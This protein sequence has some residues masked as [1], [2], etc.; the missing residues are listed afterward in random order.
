[1]SESILRIY[2]TIS[3]K[4]SREDLLNKDFTIGLVKESASYDKGR[5]TRSEYRSQ[6][7]DAMVVE[8]I[9]RDIIV[10][11]HLVGLEMTT[12]WFNEA[13][14]IGLTKTE[15]IKKLNKY[16]A[17]TLLRKRRER[18]IDYL[19][20]GAE[21]TPIEP[22]VNAIF[23]HY[24]GVIDKFEKK[25]TTEFADAINAETDQQILGMLAI[26]LPLS[27]GGSI[28]VKD[29]ILGEIS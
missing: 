13:G 7:D 27:N 3:L 12:N 28:S 29:R 21:D 24:Y 6:I 16:T 8:K 2:R 9:F 5:K 20:A 23:D 26:Q 10:N 22:Y 4:Y 19:E 25:G 14:N 11:D 18:I 15:T 17:R 1:M